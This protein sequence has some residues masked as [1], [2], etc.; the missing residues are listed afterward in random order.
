MRSALTSAAWIGLALSTAGV[1][2]SAQQ[3]RNEKQ[4]TCDN[5][6]YDGDRA[7]HCEIREQNL[8]GIGRLNVDAGNNGGATVKG[9]TR[10]DVLVRARVEASA[11]TEGAATALTSQVWIDGSGGEVRAKGP[12]AID[13]AWWSVSYEIFVPNNTDLTLKSHNGGL[14]ISDVR[15][16]IRFEAHNGGV[17]LRRV[18]GD[19]SGATHN[20]G[21]QVELA[22]NT[23]D[24]RQLDVSTHNGGVTVSMPSN[25]SAHIQAETGQGGIRSDFPLPLDG[26]NGRSRRLDF[27]LASGGP[28]IHIATGNGQVSL[29]RSDTQ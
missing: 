27:H 1:P 9:W 17:N 24:G 3:N 11:E 15:G 18:G 20:G 26:T 16:Q 23:W 2:L 14:S 4:M 22:G 29:R 28:L 8:P 25:Y 6:R 7:R 13:N 12:E 5:G 21:V 19:V 10:S